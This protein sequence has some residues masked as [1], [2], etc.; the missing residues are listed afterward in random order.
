MGNFCEVA[1]AVAIRSGNKVGIKNNAE[2][3]PKPTSLICL[4]LI[5]HF[6]SGL[7]GNN[8]APCYEIV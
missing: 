3:K 1:W 2:K 7:I 4:T 8:V 6:H 5:Q